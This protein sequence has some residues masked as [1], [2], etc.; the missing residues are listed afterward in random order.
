MPAEWSELFVSMQGMVLVSGLVLSAYST[1]H[2]QHMKPKCFNYTHISM[3]WICQEVS[4]FLVWIAAMAAV[5]WFK[6]LED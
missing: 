1:Y 5:V 2:L 4:C 6:N 3:V